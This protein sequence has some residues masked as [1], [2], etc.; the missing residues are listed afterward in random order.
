[1]TLGLPPIALSYGLMPEVSL[2]LLY[3]IDASGVNTRHVFRA[4]AGLYL[5]MVALWFLG[6]QRPSLRLP[7]LWSLFVF[8][9]GIGLG[10]LVSLVADGWPHPL[11]AGYMVLEFAL[12]AITWQLIQRN[13]SS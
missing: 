8:T 2:P 10:R 4:V 3:D 11:L 13:P 6:A 12:A 1:M 9:L 5:A 7:A